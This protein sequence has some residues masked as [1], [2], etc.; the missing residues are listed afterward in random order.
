MPESNSD[1]SQQQNL[2]TNKI[3]KQL[4]LKSNFM[5]GAAGAG[6]PQ[7]SSDGQSNNFNDVQSVMIRSRFRPEMSRN[8]TPKVSYYQHLI[9]SRRPN[10]AGVPGPGAFGGL[11]NN[12]NVL[13][14]HQQYQQ[15][16]GAYMQQSGFPNNE[17]VVSQM[18]N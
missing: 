17:E 10:F 14:Q 4:Q 2:N 15:P 13:P 11:A 9:D 16:Q 6:Q 3:G 5:N 18:A 1:V 12:S 7:Q 8:D